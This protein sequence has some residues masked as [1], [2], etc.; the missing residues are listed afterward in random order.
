M[1]MQGSP[2]F[3][4]IM[5]TEIRCLNWLFTNIEAAWLCASEFG[6]L[7]EIMLD[8][9]VLPMSSAKFCR[10]LES[11]SWDRTRSSNTK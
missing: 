10:G 11:V 4:G 2:E 5:S 9:S 1:I 7:V 6:N 3:T 8:S